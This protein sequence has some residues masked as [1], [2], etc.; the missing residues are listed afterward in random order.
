LW[1]DGHQKR[2]LIYVRDFVQAALQ[3]TDKVRNEAINIGSGVEYSI[4]SYADRI[5]EIV[6]YDPAKILYDTSRYVGV[7]SKQLS[8]HKL[9]SLLP[10]FQMTPIEMAL[11]ETISSHA[12]T[13]G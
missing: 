9:R 7:R 2:E 3:L 10:D 11:K 5:S 6:G 13:I 8:I 1:G 12:V 4:R